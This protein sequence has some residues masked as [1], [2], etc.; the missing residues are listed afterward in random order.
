MENLKFAVVGIINNNG[1]ILVS[2][3]TDYKK[4]DSLSEKWHIPGG[5][6]RES[7][8]FNSALKREIFEEFGIG[9]NVLKIVFL[10]LIMV[11]LKIYNIIL[12]YKAN[13]V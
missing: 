5:G 2:K 1:S 7:E 11:M 6:V 4:D 3:K 8:N 9:I 13:N 10:I 12:I